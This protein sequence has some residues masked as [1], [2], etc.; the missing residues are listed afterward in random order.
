MIFLTR[1]IKHNRQKVESFANI[2]LYTFEIGSIFFI[3]S[4]SGK[5]K[6]KNF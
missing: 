1:S 6:F 3:F 2:I 5:I 4:N